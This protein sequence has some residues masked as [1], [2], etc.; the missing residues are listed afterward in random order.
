MKTK[1]EISDYTLETLA[2]IAEQRRIRNE[3]MLKGDE[4]HE[5]VTRAR[6]ISMEFARE[7]RIEMLL[8]LKNNV[9]ATVED[10]KELLASLNKTEEKI[11][12]YIVE[13]ILRERSE[14]E[15][16]N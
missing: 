7:I 4:L 9:K 16:L 12:K 10:A 11:K 5:Y 13:N 8:H 14:N 6:N 2:L 3:A 15:K 1:D